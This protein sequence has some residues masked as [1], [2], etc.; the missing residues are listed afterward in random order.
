MDILEQLR[1]DLRRHIPPP[2]STVAI[3]VQR[4]LSFVN[5]L[6]P[7]YTLWCWAAVAMSISRYYDPTSAVTQCSIANAML[8][9]AN[10]TT[11]T[12]DCCSG[13]VEHSPC[14]RRFV[15]SAPLAFVGHYVD[16][17]GPDPVG[18]RDEISNLRPAGV[19]IG[20]PDGTGHFAV[21]YGYSGNQ[22]YVADPKWGKFLISEAELFGWYQLDGMWTHTYYTA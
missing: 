2:G 14:N 1:I 17:G 15:L 11:G 12:V 3:V 20:W 7:P 16:H 21:I 13:D 6:Q 18:V 5:Y 22:F 9:I 10:G 8:P 19:H 4:M